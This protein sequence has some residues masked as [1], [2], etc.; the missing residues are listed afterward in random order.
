MSTNKKIFHLSD[1]DIK[2]LLVMVDEAICNIVRRSSKRYHI[3]S[4]IDRELW[5]GL[6]AFKKRLKDYRR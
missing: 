4:P 2:L 6:I 1:G 5:S 3:L